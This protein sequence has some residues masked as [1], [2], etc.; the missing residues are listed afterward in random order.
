MAQ[1][2]DLDEFTQWMKEHDVDI[3]DVYM[4]LASPVKESV[5][6][7]ACNIK[8]SIEIRVLSLSDQPNVKIQPL[9]EGD[10]K[11]NSNIWYVDG[12]ESCPNTCSTS[13]VIF[14]ESTLLMNVCDLDGQQ[15]VKL[16][17]EVNG[18]IEHIPFLLKNACEKSEGYDMIISL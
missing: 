17:V 9:L 4:E 10:S 15:T 7:E 13:K 1:F 12:Y 2:K 3:S 5:D 14:K 6:E 16:V 8:D 18:K 11:I